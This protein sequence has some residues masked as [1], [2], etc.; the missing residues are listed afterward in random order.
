MSAAPEKLPLPS[1]LV[2]AGSAAI[3]FHLFA[4]LIVVLAVRSGPWFVPLYGPSQAFPP[5]FAEEISNLTTKGYL[6]PLQISSNYHFASNKADM[7]SVYFEARLRDAKDNVIQTIR[8]P[9][10]NANLWVWNRQVAIAQ[11][12][13]EDVQLEP[14]RSEK[15]PA[16]G[17]KLETA[18]I[19]E[20]P[21]G[22]GPQRL[23]EIPIIGIPR[24]APAFGPSEW[25]R[26]LA[27]SYSRYLCIQF[28]AASVEIIRHFRR[29]IYPV[30][31]LPNEGPGPEDLEEVICSF[32]EYRLEK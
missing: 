18:F 1:W 15:I 11:S 19:W 2:W 23:R 8:F 14:P 4:L 22:E 24:D 25:S 20:A 28:E 32:G 5:R 10:K 29:P 16:P 27:R 7:D 17:K 6:Q 21:E 30:F 3:I 9:Q 12:L 13:G 31:V 26:E